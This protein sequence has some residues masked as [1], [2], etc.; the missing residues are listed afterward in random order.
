MHRLSSIPTITITLLALSLEASA[1]TQ[2]YGSLRHYEGLPN[3]L[4]LI[5][6][7]KSG[8]SFELR[9]A[10]RDHPIDLV[11]TGSPGGNLYEGLQMASILHDKGVSTYVPKEVNCESSCANVFFG[12]VRRNVVGN[13]GV[14]QFYSA[15]EGPASEAPKDVTRSETQYTTAEIIGIMNEFETPAF[16]YERMFRTGE[17]HYFR[18]TEQQRLNIGADDP[19]FLELLADADRFIQSNPESTRRPAHDPAMLSGLPQ[20]AA[21]QPDPATGRFSDLDFFGLDI[22]PT[23]VRGISL[24][25]C[26][27]LC[28]STPS[29]AA[30]SYVTSTNWC[31]LKYGVENISIAPGTISAV[32]DFSRVNPEAIN[33][34]FVEA[35]AADIPGYDIYPRG[36]KN[37]TL[38]DCRTACERDSSCVAFSWLSKKDWCF[39]KHHV[40]TVREAFGTISGVKQ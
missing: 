6:Q 37:M 30:Y 33:R 36:L 21:T 39:P 24:T 10:M 11:I 8:D 34:P 1:Q 9:R 4:F 18:D 7:I 31:W 38:K 2:D 19:A 17:I 25:A 20:G 16:V 15:A 22:S 26:D 5:G 40:G 32:R 12:G 13:L 3:A 28:A 23:G 29:C 14:H 27:E 35:T